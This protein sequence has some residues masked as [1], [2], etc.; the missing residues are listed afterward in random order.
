MV[1][2]NA[3]PPDCCLGAVE[4]CV[5]LSVCNLPV[6]IPAIVAREREKDEGTRTGFSFGRQTTYLS[7]VNTLHMHIEPEESHEEPS[8]DPRHEDFIECK[9]SRDSAISPSGRVGYC[10]V[11][12][13]RKEPPL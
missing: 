3:D 10:A 1:L 12:V 9:C 8:K 5:A 13:P 6:L 4:N 2:P 7:T 11:C